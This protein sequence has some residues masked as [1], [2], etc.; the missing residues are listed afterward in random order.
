MN[1]QINYMIA[2]QRNVE[3]QRAGAR[4]RLARDLLA[5]RPRPRSSKPIRRLSVQLA[6]LTGRPAPTRS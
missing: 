6:R 2:Q 5:T 1:H 4:A 3:L